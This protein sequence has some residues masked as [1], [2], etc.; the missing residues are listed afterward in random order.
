MALGAARGRRKGRAAEQQA[1]AQ[2]EAEQASR[3]Q[4]TETELE[5]FK[6]AFSV[7]LE[8]KEYMVKY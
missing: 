6:K 2:V 3:E 4:Y 7:C 8:A 5:N 1:T